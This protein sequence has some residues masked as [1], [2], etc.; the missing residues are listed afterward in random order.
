[1]T[2]FE[3]NDVLKFRNSSVER[4]VIAKDGG[5]YTMLANYYPPLR[6]SHDTP[7]P[8]MLDGWTKVGVECRADWEHRNFG[9]RAAAGVEAMAD[10]VDMLPSPP[11]EG[12]LYDVTP[13]TPSM[14][15]DYERQAAFW[16]PRKE[17][18]EANAQEREDL[19]T[20]A[21]YILGSNNVVDMSDLRPVEEAIVTPKSLMS[22]I[23]AAGEEYLNARMTPLEQHEALCSAAEAVIPDRVRSGFVGRQLSADAD[24]YAYLQKR[25]GVSR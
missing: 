2:Q 13:G 6:R 18:F 19:R 17:D 1:M 10:G 5:G 4:L 20:I 21:K 3:V 12:I 22:G 15:A 23:M 24:M 25:D 14:L 8:F 7:D 16:R 9:T 11:A